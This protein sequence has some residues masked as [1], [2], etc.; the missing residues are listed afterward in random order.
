VLVFRGIAES[1]V[2]PR[3]GLSTYKFS[4][5]ISAGTYRAGVDGRMILNFILQK[6]GV[7]KWTRFISHYSPESSRSGGLW[8]PRV[9]FRM[10]TN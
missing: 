9:Y 2:G 10:H 6:Q 7:R 4:D 1:F 5:V 3:Q 8:K